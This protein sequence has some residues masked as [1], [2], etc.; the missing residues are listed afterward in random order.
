MFTIE[1]QNVVTTCVLLT[2][3][4]DTFHLTLKINNY[5]YRKRGKQISLSNEGNL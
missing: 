2:E 3:L 5:Y 4:I 1:F